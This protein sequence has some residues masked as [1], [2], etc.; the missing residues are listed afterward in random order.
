MTCGHVRHFTQIDPCYFFQLLTVH[1]D[2]IS[3]GF[4]MGG[5]MALHM[6]YRIYPNISG[7][8]VMSSFLNTGSSVYKV[9]HFKKSLLWNYF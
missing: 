2:I 4:S 7:V 9:C 5:A 6:G 3:G 1:F 8:F